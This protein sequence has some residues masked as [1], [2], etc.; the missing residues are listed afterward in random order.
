MHNL[1]LWFTNLSLQTQFLIIY[2]IVINII[3]FFYFGLD[4]L[5]SQLQHRRISEKIL[6]ILSAVGGSVGA[7]LAMNFFRHKT[8]KLSFQAG[9]AMILAGQILIVLFLI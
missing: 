8:K 1:S 4:K 2:L 5:K 6:W 7:L 9:I 3:T